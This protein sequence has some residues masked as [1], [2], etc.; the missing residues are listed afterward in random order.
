MKHAVIL[1]GIGI[2]AACSPGEERNPAL[3]PVTMISPDS[4][5]QQSAR[6]SPDGMRIFWW[7]PTG[8]GNQL[9][10]AGAD[11]SNPTSVPVT[12]FGD[13]PF[14]WSPDGSQIA[15]PSSDSGLLQVGL[16]PAAGGAPRQL[17]RVPGIAVPVAWNPDGDRLIYIATAAGNGGGTVR[18]FVTSLSRGGTSLLIPE[19]QRPNIGQWSPDGSR[20]AYVVIDGAQNTIWVADSTGHHPRQL[21]SDGFEQFA[22]GPSAWSPDGR[23]VAYESRRTGTSDIWVVPVDSGAPRQ[24]TRDIRNDWTPRWSPDGK[25]VAFLSDRGKQTDLWVVPAAGGQEVRV[26]D[27]VDGEELMQ[28]LSGTRL[29]FL[30]GRG[31]GGIWAL[32]L[33]D[34]TERR[35]TPD[36]L[37]AAGPQLSPDGKQVAFRVDRGGGVNDIAIVPLAG[38]PMRTL[39]QGG[40]NA[41]ISW[42]PDG[43]R[44][45]FSSDR[46]GS[47]DI[48]TVDAAGGDPRQLTNW[49]GSESNPRWN[50][51]GSATLVPVRPR[52]P[53]RR[54]L[55]G[56]LDRG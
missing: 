40:N 12:A 28:W 55:A 31:Q 1:A 24:L 14:L 18:S 52:H 45:V 16:I 3:P 48:W 53:A 27:D 34:R 25:W 10:T 26:T 11:L 5:N 54:C 51:D 9:W 15:V 50:V 23:E 41:E 8:G 38:G 21:T 7:Q 43:T 4:A 39:V 37:R 6:F 49:P 2:L 30:T 36:S 35:L 46:G 22:V 20:I 47:Q 42:S 32:S 44:L 29:A 13:N 17:T 19:E 56:V 33:N